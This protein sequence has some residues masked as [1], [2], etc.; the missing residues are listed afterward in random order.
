MVVPDHIALIMDGNGRWARTHGKARSAG[1]KVGYEHIPKVLEI[2]QELGV[3][4]V[5]G[6]AWST[7]NWGRPSAEVQFIMRALEKH[8]PRF[9]RELHGRGV[10]FV[11]SGRRQ[12]LSVKALAVLDEAVTLTKDNGLPVFNLAFN[13]GGRD[14]IIQATR[15]ILQE[16]VPAEQIDQQSFAAHLYTIDMPDVDLIIRTGGDKRLSNFLLW[17]SA[18]ACLFIVDHYWPAVNREDINNAVAYYNQVN[19]PS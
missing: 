17:Q 5:S 14:E 4:Y 7:E 12:D 8:L 2:C 15:N 9:V 3:S 1:H 18:Y 6:Y 13:Y 11:H 16:E 10:R 19:L